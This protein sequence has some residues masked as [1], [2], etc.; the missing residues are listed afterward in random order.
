MNIDQLKA[1]QAEL[2]DGYQNALNAV[3]AIGV[4]GS[5]AA[6]LLNSPEF[7]DLQKELTKVNGQLEDARRQQEAAR[8]EAVR[9]ENA[10]AIKDPDAHLKK[11]NQRLKRA[12]ATHDKARASH[13]RIQAHKADKSTELASVGLKIEKREA[14]ELLA[15]LEGKDIPESPD[16]IGE[17]LKAESGVLVATR[18]VEVA[19][20]ELK[21]AKSELAEAE[22]NIRDFERILENQKEMAAASQALELFIK[23]TGGNKE[24]LIHRLGAL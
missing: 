21:T 16:L 18:A 10:D 5:E 12:Q 23:A 22:R 17:R 11:L 24:R 6:K 4:P 8:L 9:A 2:M 15:L 19:A 13:D 7:L 3:K 20:T 14:D 1:R